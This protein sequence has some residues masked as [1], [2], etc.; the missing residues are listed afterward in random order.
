MSRSIFYTCSRDGMR[1][2]GVRGGILSPFRISVRTSLIQCGTRA[3]ARRCAAT[4]CR[5]WT[6]LVRCAYN[7]TTRE[8]FHSISTAAVRVDRDIKVLSWLAVELWLVRARTGLLARF[9]REPEGSGMTGCSIEMLV[10]LLDRKLTLNEKLRV[11]DHLDRCKDC[12]QVVQRIW[13]ERDRSFFIYEKC[14]KETTAA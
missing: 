9:S 8:D 12:R 6:R 2:H 3:P 11:F 10:R 4:L 5:H 14:G 1:G 13:R 7:F